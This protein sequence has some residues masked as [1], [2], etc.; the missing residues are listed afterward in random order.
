MIWWRAAGIPSRE[1]WLGVLLQSA[2]CIGTAVWWGPLMAHL[3]S[4]EG[5]LM[6]S[7][8]ASPYFPW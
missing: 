7:T 2:L 8:P 6:V 5:I 4:P 1:V 3:E